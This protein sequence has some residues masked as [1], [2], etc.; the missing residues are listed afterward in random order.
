M[1][2]LERAHACIAWS[3]TALIV[4]DSGGYEETKQVVE[5]NSC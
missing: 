3:K 5:L 4:D 1:A 2:M